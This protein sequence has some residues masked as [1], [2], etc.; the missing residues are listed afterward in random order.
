[1]TPISR[2]ENN[3]K[4]IVRLLTEDSCCYSE[5]PPAA[6]EMARK[7]TLESWFINMRDALQG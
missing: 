5:M 7:L 1:M 6:Y 2:K 4:R 3:I